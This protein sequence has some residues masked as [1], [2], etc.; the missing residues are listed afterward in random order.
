[1]EAARRRPLGLRADDSVNTRPSSASGGRL[2][3]HAS[4]QLAGEGRCASGGRSALHAPKTSTPAAL[5]A[6]DSIYT[7]PSS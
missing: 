1:M 7:R 3:L 4:Q 5:P 2:D 6:D